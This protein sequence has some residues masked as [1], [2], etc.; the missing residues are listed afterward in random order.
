MTKVPAHVVFLEIL[1]Q[2]NKA[3][4]EAAENVRATDHGRYMSLAAFSAL[5]NDQ[6][7][8]HQ[9]R[10][11]LMS[12]ARISYD[13][14]S[15][16]S[17]SAVIDENTPIKISEAQLDQLVTWRNTHFSSID[18]DAINLIVYGVKA[19]TDYAPA[20]AAC[21]WLISNTNNLIM[22]AL[23]ERPANAVA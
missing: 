11:S 9:T 2:L 23:I 13:D 3:V 10:I 17:L 16:I 18:T 12:A 6:I 4:S 1:H 14:L 19:N 20:V 22:D 21:N 8:R 5:I 15:R 7:S